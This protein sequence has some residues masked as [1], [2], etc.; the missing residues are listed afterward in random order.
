MRL[1]EF[2]DPKAY[3]LPRDNASDFV[4]Y[5]RHISP[6]RSADDLASPARASKRQP[7]VTPRKLLDEL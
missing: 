2:A 7:L 6:D 1:I 4:R 3:T 5:L